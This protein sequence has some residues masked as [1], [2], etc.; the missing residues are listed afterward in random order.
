[1]FDLGRAQ[2]GLRSPTWSWS[3]ETGGWADSCGVGC[4]G[5]A[6]RGRLDGYFATVGG[7]ILD[8]GSR[9][10]SL[11]LG[12]MAEV[13][14]H[15]RLLDGSFGGVVKGGCF[16]GTGV[17]VPNCGKTDCWS[18]RYSCYRSGVPR[19][20]DGS[21]VGQGLFGAG[22]GKGGG[23]P[24]LQ[25]QGVGAGMSSVRLEGALGRH[26]TYVSTGNPSH[27]KGNGKRGNGRELPVPG[28]G[29]LGLGKKG[30]V[31]GDS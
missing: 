9:V 4:W 10:G 7:K 3:S 12:H 14:F 27:R 28:A 26:Q 8:S 15:R 24:G 17:D 2:A 11:G 6:G 19:Y 13:V 23:M 21:G 20:F 16:P 18:T 30:G 25:G 1:M 22:P 29:E 31:S 5:D